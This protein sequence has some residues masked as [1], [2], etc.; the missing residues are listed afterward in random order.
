MPQPVTANASSQQGVVD[1][2]RAL[3]LANI[4]YR[5]GSLDLRSVQQQQVALDSA[6]G[7]LLHTQSDRLVRSS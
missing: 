1:N 5:V 7:A 6:R 2:S 4:R 3:E